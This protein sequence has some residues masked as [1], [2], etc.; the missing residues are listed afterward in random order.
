MVKKILLALAGVLALLALA[1]IVLEVAIDP[2]DYKEQIR[3]RAAQQ[4]ID[5][6]LKGDIRWSFFPRPAFDIAD[7]DAVLPV[8]MGKQ[9]LHI[10]KLEMALAIAPLFSK[11]IEFSNIGIEGASM[12]LEDKDGKQKNLDDIRLL[13]TDLNSSGRPFPVSLSLLFTQADLQVPIQLVTEASVVLAEGQ[14]ANI[15]LDPLE[16]IV[17][18]NRIKGSVQWQSG[19]PDR[20]VLDLKSDKL[21]AS[22]LIF[23]NV[24]LSATFEDNKLTLQTLQADAYQGR[25]ST[26]GSFTMVDANASQLRLDTAIKGMQ[27][28]PLLADLQQKPSKV[29]AGT[30]QLDS[31]LTATPQARAGMLRTLSGDLQF[32]IDGLVIDEMNLE[33]RV[34]EAAAQL[35]GK[36]LSAKQW[37]EKTELRETRGTAQIRN[38]VMVLS[39]LVARLD[40]LDMDGSGPVIL[41]DNAMDLR[42]DLKVVDNRQAANACE[43][44]NPRLADISWPLRCRG[45]FATQSGKE[46]CGIDQSRLD[47][48]LLQAAGQKLGDKIKE[49]FR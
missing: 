6:V 49:L 17:N 15:A 19:K 26:S 48:L 29:L 37:P 28:A 35:D 22:H 20:A 8:G 32:V 25:I 3:Q 44:T 23:T 43:V 30:L 7:V 4:N 36:S 11:K 14:V 10:D 40:T 24:L 27:L 16:L 2:N 21:V 33:K 9:P 39:P 46:L 45:N 12:R 1:L 18:D 41:A 47:K 13:V 42:L 34:C 31:R 38:G 5:L